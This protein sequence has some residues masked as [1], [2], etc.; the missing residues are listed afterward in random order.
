MTSVV[1]WRYRE[2][3]IKYNELELQGGR[4]GAVGRAGRPPKIMVGEH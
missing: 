3:K 2:N 4:G 1:I